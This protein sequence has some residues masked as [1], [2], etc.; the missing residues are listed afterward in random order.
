MYLS[1]VAAVNGG[2]RWKTPAFTLN[3]LCGSGL[4]AIVSAAQ[5]V[6]LGDTDVALADEVEV[7]SR[8][9]YGVPA[10]RARAPAWARPRPPT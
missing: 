1:R 6:L 5:L 7:M 3:R 9:L 2:C 10:M 4:Q 8:G